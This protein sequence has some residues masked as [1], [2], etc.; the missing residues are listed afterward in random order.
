MLSKCILFSSRQRSKNEGRK[1]EE[2]KESPSFR[3]NG[4][5]RSTSRY[6]INKY[7]NNEDK[8]KDLQISQNKEKSLF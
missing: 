8:E 7:L 3:E 5:K 1:F 6:V 2:E 4:W